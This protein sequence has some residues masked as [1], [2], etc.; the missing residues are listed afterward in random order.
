MIYFIDIQILVRNCSIGDLWWFHWA[1]N[2]LIQ[3][4][5]SDVMLQCGF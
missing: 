1:L 3:I 2:L 4:G 5:S